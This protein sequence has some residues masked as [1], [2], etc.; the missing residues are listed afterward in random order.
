MTTSKEM[1]T[2]TT[3]KKDTKAKELLEVKVASNKLKLKKPKI[4]SNN[5]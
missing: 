5:K 3:R 1:L 2:N 4:K